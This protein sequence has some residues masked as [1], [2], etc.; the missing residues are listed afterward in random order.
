MLTGE[1]VNHKGEK[2]V[3]HKYDKDI[4]PSNPHAHNYDANVKATFRNWGTI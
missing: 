3:L 1:V 2:W 4:F